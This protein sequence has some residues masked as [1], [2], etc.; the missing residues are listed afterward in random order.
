MSSVRY[1]ELV[2]ERSARITDVY[3]REYTRR[4]K[5]QV[6]SKEDG[7]I[8][9]RTTTGIPRVGDLYIT[10]TDFD[11]GCRCTSVDCEPNHD[12]P[13][14]WDVTCRY[15]NETADPSRSTEVNSLNP[16]LRPADV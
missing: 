11:T 6:S 12:S 10:T 9:V 7:P 3:R 1:W 15:S 13:Y 14:I 8:T 16:V 2:E 4:F 5:V